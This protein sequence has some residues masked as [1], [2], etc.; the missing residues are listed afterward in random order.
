M[1]QCLHDIFLFNVILLAVKMRAKLIPYFFTSFSIIN[2]YIF[3][4]SLFYFSFFQIHILDGG[5]L[6]RQPVAQIQ[7]VERFLDLPP[8]LGPHNFYYNATKGFY[9]L[10]PFS[11]TSPSCLG[12]TKGRKHP[13]LN[14]TVK[15]LLY[16]FYRPY[17][18]E[19]F[20]VIGKRFD[21]EPKDYT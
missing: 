7:M 1:S 2:E 21:W 13:Q 6:K 5:A 18:E 16:D 8:L 9:C 19:F 17:N 10:V 14:D 15:T 4:F 20:K 12:K 3:H 11:A